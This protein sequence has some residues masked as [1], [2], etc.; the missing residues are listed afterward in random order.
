VVRPA[1]LLKCCWNSA[2]NLKSF[3]ITV[4][5][6]LGGREGVQ[7]LGAPPRHPRVVPQAVQV[8]VTRNTF[9]VGKI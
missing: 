9:I 5:E 6:V 1:D 3:W 2:E 4:P 8:L 7:E